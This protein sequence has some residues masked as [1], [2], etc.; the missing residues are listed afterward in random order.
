MK[1][2][3][4]MATGGGG[5]GETVIDI[6]TSDEEVE[7]ESV[8]E[9]LTGVKHRR[10]TCSVC[11][12]ETTVHHC[13]DPLCDTDLCKLCF[14]KCIL[15]KFA[16]PACPTCSKAF[17]REYLYDTLGRTFMMGK[18]KKHWE[19][20]LLERQ[21]AR[22][23]VMS[24][25][26]GMC[27]K[28]TASIIED[29][30]RLT[31]DVNKLQKEYLEEY[32][33]LALRDLVAAPKIPNNKGISKFMEETHR[34]RLIGFKAFED[35][36]EGI[37]M[38]KSLQT[39]ELLFY[40][41]YVN[42]ERLENGQYTI[43][44]Y[45]PAKQTTT[46]NGAPSFSSSSS[47]AV[48]V[49]PVKPAPSPPKAAIVHQ[50]PRCPG[51][52]S[53]G[54][55][56]ICEV[57]ICMECMNV[58]SENHVC[59]PDDLKTMSLLVKDSVSCPQCKVII[60]KASG[61]NQMF[62]VQCNTAFDFKTGT[63]QTGPIHNPHYFEYIKEKG[64]IPA[65][66]DG[67]NNPNNNNNGACLTIERAIMNHRRHD[68]ISHADSDTLLQRLRDSRHILSRP[69]DFA[70]HVQWEMNSASVKYLTSEYTEQVYKSK[71]HQIHKASSRKLDEFN[72]VRS[73]ATLV[74]DILHNFAFGTG[75]DVDHTLEMLHDAET[76]CTTSLEKIAKIYSSGEIHRIHQFLETPGARTLWH[77]S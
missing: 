21:R 17:G 56:T 64:I 23:P 41:E 50:C 58:K 24:E 61:C 25:R 51:Y 9:A 57:P 60:H 33:G 18:F 55:C 13:I 43:N 16:D 70:E 66:R 26:I 40:Q 6:T 74:N 68:G 38:F 62:C 29:K 28:K 52:I 67:G 53:D 54:A 10:D 2:S 76:M 47:K 7:E 73:Y 44:F 45:D 4:T 35:A 34:C 3:T 48:K 19:N 77:W 46:V 27:R 20:V 42:I 31:L 15:S 1:R 14:E 8:T 71:I 30:K 59:N 49:V 32:H 12:E 75:S 37:E 36:L 22:L 5:G 69:L 65:P 72:T 11:Y 39:E 63:I